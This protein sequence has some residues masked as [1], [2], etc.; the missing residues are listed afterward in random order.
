MTINSG[1]DITINSGSVING[2]LNAK[3]NVTVKKG[4]VVNGSVNADKDAHIDGVVSGS[5]N[6]D[7]KVTGSGTYRN[8][9]NSSNVSG[10]FTS[11]VFGSNITIGGMSFGNISGGIISING[12]GN[13]SFNTDGNMSNSNG[14]TSINNATR[15]EVTIDG[16][17]L[18][19]T[20]QHSITAGMVIGGKV[21]F[22]GKDVVADGKGIV[23]LAELDV[24]LSQEFGGA[25]SGR[26]R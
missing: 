12:K 21:K 20:G 13:K 25:G 2:S 18:E 19:V 10:S 1:G 24:K 6:A 7:G 4:A 15:T 22:N 16:S 17:K 9:A 8:S 23:E 3:G 11:R 5:V 14:T 26:V